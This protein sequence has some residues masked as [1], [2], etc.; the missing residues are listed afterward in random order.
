MAHGTS[1]VNELCLG[2]D[3]IVRM[4]EVKVNWKRYKRAVRRLIP[5]DG[6][7]LK[8]D[9]SEQQSLVAVSLDTLM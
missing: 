1:Y 2:R 6:E 9:G 3:G 4:C 8:L 7:P 5:L